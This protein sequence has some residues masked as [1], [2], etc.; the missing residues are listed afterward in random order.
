MKRFKQFLEENLISKKE[1]LEWRPPNPPDSY[2]PQPGNSDSDNY[3]R[4]PIAPAAGPRRPRPPGIGNPNNPF[5]IYDEN[6]NIIGT[7]FNGDGNPDTEEELR[8]WAENGLPPSDWVGDIDELPL[9][10]QIRERFF[11][12]LRSFYEVGTWILPF[13]TISRAASLFS[14]ILFE[15]VK[16][17]SIIL[18]FLDIRDLVRFIVENQDI[19]PELYQ[20]LQELIEEVGFNLWD[21]LLLLLIQYFETSGEEYVPSIPK[22][23]YRIDEFGNVQLWRFNRST[24]TWERY[25]EPITVQDYHAMCQTGNC[26]PLENPSNPY[27]F[28][29]PLPSNPEVVTDP[30]FVVEPNPNPNPN[31]D[32]WQLWQPANSNQTDPNPFPWPQM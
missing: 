23:F 29:P 19:F 28:K 15:I 4:L 14:R 32:I 27:P 26:P 22:Q 7:D 12:F 17:G 18:D 30:L 24:G 31:L 20:A 9:Y 25:G 2:V 6:G 5:F 16:H 1:L 10:E 21:D 3:V 11:L 8:Q 13:G